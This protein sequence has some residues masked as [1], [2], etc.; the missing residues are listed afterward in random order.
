VSI[1][2]V[3][4]TSNSRV[5][6][7]IL[8]VLIVVGFV[9]SVIVRRYR[10][11][12]VVAP[13]FNLQSAGFNENVLSVPNGMY[14]DKSHTWAF[15]EK[16]GTISVGIDDFLQHIT[17]PI[18]RVEMKNPGEKIKKGDLLFSI[19]QSGKQL[20]MY[21]PVSGTIKKQNE[22]LSTNASFLNTSPYSN[23]WV[24]SLDPVNW[25]GENQLLSRAD[26]HKRWLSTEFSRVKDFFAAALKPGS[27]E[28]TH[29][30]LQDGG[31]LKEGILADFGPEVWEDFQTN[32]LDNYK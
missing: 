19:I 10:K 18:T 14:F 3:K 11:Q 1:A 13:E 9:V 30:I 5:I 15:M 17:G 22:I 29:V 27:L 8:A 7:L 4:E 23:G 6:V 25:F 2:P 24:Y 12:S 20:S 16:D 21:S 31:V 32:F 28:Y 26:K